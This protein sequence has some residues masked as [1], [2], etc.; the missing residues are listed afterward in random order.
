MDLG[1]GREAWPVRLQMELR[2]TKGPAAGRFTLVEHRRDL[3]ELVPEDFPQQEDRALEWLE[4]LQQDQ[5]GQ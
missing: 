3:G 1:R 5:E 4:L 2:P